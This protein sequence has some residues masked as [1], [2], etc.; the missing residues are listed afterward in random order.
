MSSEVWNDYLK[1]AVERNPW[2]RQ[3]SLYFHREWKKSNANPSFDSDMRSPWYR[4]TE[5]CRLNNWSI[6]AIGKEI[7][8]DRILRFETLDDD[9]RQ[10]ARDLGIGKLDL[11]KKRSHYRTERPHYSTYYSDETRDMIARWYRREIEALN[12]E[13]ED[14]RA[15]APQAAEG[16]QRGTAKFDSR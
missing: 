8:A 9:L 11:P 12:Y 16:W 14:R 7:V 5:Y 2:D 6:Y 4:G 15:D 13:F 10:L 1:F 3:V